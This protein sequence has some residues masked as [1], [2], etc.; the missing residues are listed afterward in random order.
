MKHDVE[1]AR[2]KVQ[3]NTMATVTMQ[4]KGLFG[5]D[6]S[7]FWFWFGS[8][9]GT[10]DPTKWPVVG[11]SDVISG[12]IWRADSNRHHIFKCPVI[13]KTIVVFRPLGS[14]GL[15]G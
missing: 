8:G 1:K 14:A 5:A 4:A 11:T 7:S 13:D 2:C 6:D 10:G 3:H 9:Y 12:L 15:R